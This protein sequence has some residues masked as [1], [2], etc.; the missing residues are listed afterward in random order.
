MWNGETCAIRFRGLQREI[1]EST[2]IG[3]P[4]SKADGAETFN[5]TMA[6]SLLSLF[7]CPIYFLSFLLPFIPY[8]FRPISATSQFPD[9]L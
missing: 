5:Q 8:S 2:R 3:R 1:S 9:Q 7:S 4:N 6:I